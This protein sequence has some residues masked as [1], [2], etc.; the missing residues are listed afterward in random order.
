MN[1]VAVITGA[2][3]GIGEAT[4][5]AAAALDETK[6]RAEATARL[7]SSS[8]GR[9]GLALERPGGAGEGFEHGLGER[10]AAAGR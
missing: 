10:V 4:D 5:R 1:R 6:K 8:E 9:S 2:S 7:V 3:S